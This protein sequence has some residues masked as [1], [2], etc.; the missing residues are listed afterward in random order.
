MSNKNKTKKEDVI[1]SSVIEKEKKDHKNLVI[2]LLVLVILVLLLVLS[3]FVFF[4][5]EKASGKCSDVEIKEVEVEPKYQYINYQGFKLK[6][7][8]EWDFVSLDNVYEISD[9]DSKIHIE[10]DY[11]EEDYNKFIEKDYQKTYLEELQTSDDI[12]INSSE[13]KDNYY[14]FEGTKDS[15]DYILVAVG[16]ENKTILVNAI[17]Q[18][19][20]SYNNYSKDVIKFA[21]SY[22]N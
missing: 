9:S 4:K 15:Y 21:T 12:T 20:V 8:L 13:E 14:I 17:F 22:K 2:I 6:M 1:V 5:E 7:P 3:Y 18:D 11:L 10:L 19:K 16:N